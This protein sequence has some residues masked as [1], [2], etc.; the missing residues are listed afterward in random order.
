MNIVLLNPQSTSSLL[1]ITTLVVSVMFLAHIH[2]TKLHNFL[3][4]PPKTTR[5][6]DV[7]H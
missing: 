1:T 6:S 4:A 7:T 3:L 5:N 2:G